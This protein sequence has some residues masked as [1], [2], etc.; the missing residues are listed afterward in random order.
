MDE[1]VVHVSCD[2]SLF[3]KHPKMDRLINGFLRELCPTKQTKVFSA[4]TAGVIGSAMLA[5]C[6]H[7]NNS[8]CDDSK[9]NPNS[10]CQ[11]YRMEIVWRNIFLMITLHMASV[12]GA[13]LGIF[14]A[15][16]LTVMFNYLYLIL[17]GLG[18]T[19]GAHRLWA[20]R[21]Y[22]ATKSARILLMLLNCGALQ[23]DI[24]EWSRDHR[25]HHKFS[26]TDA[27]P[28]NSRRG[29]FFAHIGWLMCRKHPDVREK[30]RT[31]SMKDIADD[32]VVQFQ[33]RYYKPLAA[34]FTFI[35][36]SY[37]PCVCWNED[38]ITSIFAST[39]RYTLLLVIVL[40]YH[41]DLDFI[42]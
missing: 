22:E 4:Q 19:A 1:Q 21:S 37:I 14:H 17:T 3:A 42:D 16:Y 34:L 6:Y 33:R 27:D 40:S 20:H 28:H 23:N 31:V 38:P 39:T 36:P 29:F 13:Y 30:G 18:I 25:V 11:S 8:H 7:H 5:A 15:R 24:H 26:E 32:P 41:S 35:L 2:G 9:S 10:K 12:Y